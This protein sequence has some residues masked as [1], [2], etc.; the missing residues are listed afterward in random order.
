MSDCKTRIKI[1]KVPAGGSITVGRSPIAMGGKVSSVNGQTGDVIL[2][3]ED[4]GAVSPGQLD[5][6]LEEYPKTDDLAEVAFT[7]DY[8]DV[9]HRPTNFSEDEWDILWGEL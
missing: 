9:E 7:G 1:A 6:T 5:A 8:D 2:N 4:V 3:A